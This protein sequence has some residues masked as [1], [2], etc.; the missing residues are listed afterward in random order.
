MYNEIL[1]G[2]RTEY[3]ETMSNIAGTMGDF[4][5]KHASI[6]RTAI[7]DSS[8]FSMVFGVCACEN[9]RPRDRREREKNR[10]SKNA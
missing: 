9:A 5:Y 3:G 4:C 1:L 7:V 2:Y 6:K 8:Q 10:L